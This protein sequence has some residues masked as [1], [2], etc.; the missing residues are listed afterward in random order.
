MEWMYYV[1]LTATILL[2]TKDVPQVTIDVH[3]DMTY[4]PVMNFDQIPEK[5]GFFIFCRDVSEN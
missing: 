4:A 5:A 2:I 3:E 1:S